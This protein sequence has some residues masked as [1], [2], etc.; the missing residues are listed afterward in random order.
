MEKMKK[1]P[2]PKISVITPSFNQGNFIAE[3][4]DSVLSQ[5]YKNLEYWIIDGGSKDDTIPV[6]KRYGKKI[7]W[8]SKKD[9]GQTDAINKGMEKVTGDIVTYL[10]SDDI[11]LPGS[12]EKI[13]DF[14]STNPDIFWTTGM[15]KIINEKGKEI[16]KLITLYKNFWLKYFR[17]SVSLSVVNFISQPATF[18]RRETVKSVG[19]FDTSLYYTMDYDYWLRMSRIYKLGFIDDYLASF[20]LHD[21]SKSSKNVKKLFDEGYEVVKEHDK[22]VLPIIHRLHDIFTL[23]AY[24]VIK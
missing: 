4:I 13:A 2:L 21:E 1:N 24:T 8:M 5:G 6:L 17:N 15:C 19:L 20:R 22:G 23:T 7:Q 11:L 9:N 12:I 10:N 3:T 14:F 16:R 18:W